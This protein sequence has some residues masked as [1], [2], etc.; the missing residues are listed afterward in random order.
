M[1]LVSAFFDCVLIRPDSVT[2]IGTG[3]QALAMRRVVERTLRVSLRDV[4]GCA[5]HEAVPGQAVYLLCAMPKHEVLASL[6]S[7]GITP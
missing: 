4:V 3:T 5:S 1:H 7:R 2:V 6:A